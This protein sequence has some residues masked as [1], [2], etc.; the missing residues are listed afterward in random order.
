MKLFG[1]KT[2]TKSAL[3][4][5]QFIKLD[6]PEDGV[7]PRVYADISLGKKVLDLS[8]DKEF[9]LLIKKA[10][11]PE[12]SATKMVHTASPTFLMNAEPVTIHFI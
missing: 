10:I 9:Y 6:T 1:K 4:H 5:P 7:I 2:E 11:T 12:I 3:D 8:I